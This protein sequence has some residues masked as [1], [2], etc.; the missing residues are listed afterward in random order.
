VL[1][2]IPAR[3]LH[4]QPSPHTWNV[5]FGPVRLGWLDERDHRIHAAEDESSTNAHLLPIRP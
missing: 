3:R 5:F 1:R 2:A 4:A